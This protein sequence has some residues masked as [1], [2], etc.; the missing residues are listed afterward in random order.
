MKIHEI[1]NESGIQNVILVDFQPA[2]DNNIADRYRTAITKT[3]ADI[4]KNKPHNIL[5]FY[6]GIEM[7][8]DDDDDSVRDH[9]IK[10]G[11]A[12][13]IAYDI[14]FRDKVYSFFRAWMDNGVNTNTIIKVIRHLVMNGMNDSRDI[15]NDEMVE[16]I[17]KNEYND[18]EDII[19]TDPLYIPEIAINELKKYSGALIGGG[20]R[21]E[22]LAEI[23]ILMNAFNIKYKMV[24]DWIY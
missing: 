21:D 2:Y 3:M 5:A 14:T 4:N 6:N 12:E 24:D 1:L 7:D 20:G 19:N 8:F 15:T 13:D 22:C 10:Y 18:V 17:G 16:L 23:K 11:L 9:F